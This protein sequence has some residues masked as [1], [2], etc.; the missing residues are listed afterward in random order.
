MDRAFGENLTKYQKLCRNSTKMLWMVP[1]RSG[2]RFGQLAGTHYSKWV[3]N[4]NDF[5]TISGDF[6]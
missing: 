4:P 6:A 2:N 1:K 5:H 3:H